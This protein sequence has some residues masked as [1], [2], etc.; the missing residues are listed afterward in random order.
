MY[1]AKTPT[2]VFNIIA[3]MTR[4]TPTKNK[5]HLDNV[6]RPTKD[7]KHLDNVQHP[8]CEIAGIK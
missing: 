4:P 3:D 8:L 1:E 5:K 7:K 6:Q 2:D